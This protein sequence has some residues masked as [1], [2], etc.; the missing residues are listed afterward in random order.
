M[1]FE[2]N[3]R[4]LKKSGLGQPKSERVSREWEKISSRKELSTREKLERLIRLTRETRREKRTF[5]LEAA[6]RRPPLQVFENHFPVQSRYGRV[7][8][9]AGLRIGGKA[10]SFL[11]RNESFRSLDLRSALFLDCETTGLSGGVGVVAF[12]VGLGFYSQDKFHVVQFFLGDLAAEE[13]LIRELRLFFSQMDF[14]SVVT[15][16]GKA[17]DL[18]LLETRFILHRENLVLS[19]LPHLDFLFPARSLWGHRHE[20]CR[21]FYLAR[22]VLNADRAEDIPSAEIP[23][24]YFQFLRSGEFEL[25]EPVL[26]HNQEDI[27]SLLGLVT[28]GGSL[29]EGETEAWPESSP[30]GLDFYGVARILESRGELDLSA[31]FIERALEAKLPEEISVLAKKKLAHYFKHQREWEQAVRLWEEITPLGHLASFRELAMYYEHREKDYARARQLAEEGFVLAQG[32]SSA[33]SRDFARRLERLTRKL[34]RLRS[35]SGDK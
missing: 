28:V 14:R 8:L 17:F 25:I 29:V 35:T 26:Y 23:A 19:E 34:A 10:L 5:V 12:L 11:S 20:S 33:Y 27:L 24:R 9:T 22:E 31:R 4:P 2:D 16:N 3:G 32:V 15:F 13:Q 18:P 30:D 6:E 21:L 7:P 1:D